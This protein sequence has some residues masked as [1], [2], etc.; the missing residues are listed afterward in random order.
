MTQQDVCSLLD[1]WHIGPYLLFCRLM[2]DY[3]V[4]L[5]N[6]NSTF[7]FYEVYID[8]L[9]IQ[10]A[11]SVCFHTFDGTQ[12]GVID[13]PGYRQEFYVRFKGP[14]ESQSLPHR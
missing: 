7:A 6:D 14:E 1:T 13:N 2:S 5:V 12:G 10:A 3:E 11:F 8:L 4:T 9:L